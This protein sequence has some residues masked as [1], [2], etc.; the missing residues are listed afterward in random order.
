VIPIDQWEPAA[1]LVLEPNAY[2]AATSMSNIVVTAGP[3]A[4]KTELYADGIHDS[5]Y[6]MAG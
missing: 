2:I 4:G 1:E 3:G 6:R 5:L